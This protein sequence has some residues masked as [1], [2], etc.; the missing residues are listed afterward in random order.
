MSESRIV[1]GHTVVMVKLAEP[2]GAEAIV[3]RGESLPDNLAKGEIERLE[4]VGAF[5]P[6]P[7]AD[8]V[9]QGAA[10]RPAFA[11]VPVVQHVA[12]DLPPRG[13]TVLPLPPQV[14]L[15]ANPEP[16]GGVAKV[17]DEPAKETAA[18]RSGQR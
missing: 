5:D 3:R 11:N 6:P 13:D 10:R 4:K 15:A 2:E 18:R 17:T 14:T 1:T 8:L 16:D 9:G 7:Q 12:Q